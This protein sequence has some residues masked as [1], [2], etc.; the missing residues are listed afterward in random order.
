MA[1]LHS[2]FA[3]DRPVTRMVARLVGRRQLA[4][5][6]ARGLPPS[7]V[8]PLSF[9]VDRSLPGGDYG[10]VDRIESL[11]AALA[12]TSGAVGSYRYA[13][14]PA[15]GRADEATPE[16]RSLADVA[17]ISSVPPL[18]GV[19]LH[20]CARATRAR[21]I[22]ELGAAAGISGAYLASSPT[23][24][25]FVTVEGDADRAALA[26]ATI[27][28]VKP[29][30]EVLVA[31]FDAGLDML[32]PTFSA[33]IDLVFVDGNKTPGGY[34]A[35][36]DRFS[37]RLNPGAL[38]IFDD[39]QWTAMAG[40]WKTLRARQGLSL[41]LSVGRFG[42]C[43]WQGGAIGPHSAALFGLGGLDLYAL[44]RDAATKV[45]AYVRGTP[46]GT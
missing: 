5:L 31:T 45:A 1:S 35:L 4:R 41:A 23:C 13:A 28:A 8:E 11:R 33:G 34:L 17:H 10:P 2:R 19:F 26:R 37:A 32:L 22:L 30:A 40:D 16:I 18:W 6:R 24:T 39:I 12:S 21:T 3:P 27:G 9:L 29:G 15:S 42:L 20:V 46:P 7:L 38:V 14:P 36:F 25:R 44:R 43:V